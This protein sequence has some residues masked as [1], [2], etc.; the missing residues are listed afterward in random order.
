[1]I[2]P[3]PQTL[4]FNFDGIVGP[5]HNYAGL[6]QG[7]L[8]SQQNRHL[9]S[10]PKKAAL[11]GLAKMKFLADLGV[12]QAVLPPPLRPDL[13][14]LRHLGFSGSDAH[15]L[16]TAARDAPQ[17][18]AACSSASAMWAA[19]AATVSPSADTADHRVHFT[20]ANLISHLHRSLETPTT[21]AL[22][23]AIFEGEQFVH[24]DPL[25]AALE[26]SDEGAANHCRL[27][28]DFAGP[29]IELFVYGIDPASPTAAAPFR[30]RQSKTAGESIARLH[31]LSPERTLFAR[32]NP[33]AIAAGV[34][35][36]DVI[37]LAHLHIFLYHELA[38][39]D[40]AILLDS[41][42][43]TFSRCN[44][45]ELLTVC[46]PDSLLPLADAVRSYFFNSQLISLPTGALAFIA[47]AECQ[48]IPTASAALDFLK[49]KISAL[50]VH[51]VHVR[52][53]M[54][55]GGGPACL[56]LRVVLTPAEQAAIHPNFRLT[57]DLYAALQKWIETHYRESLS[58]PDLADPQL[59]AESR[60]AHAALKAL[61]LPV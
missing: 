19:N 40:S 43:S 6:A 48:E 47:P 42:R 46:I 15:I 26:T 37:A 23:R 58:P 45:S 50:A 25:P 36:N 57:P 39:A 9:V 21:A 13:D 3:A 8:A 14:A 54:K 20:P 28:R 11:E 51:F 16:E 52:E 17:L 7:N 10:H 55:N 30:P 24:H 22:L 5:T 41:L 33:A 29:G 59:L 61:H 31:Q 27:A 49:E 60:T 56:R 53:S 12:P 2:S 38:F 18:L 4:E 35:H 1:M 44:G 32:Q 34:F